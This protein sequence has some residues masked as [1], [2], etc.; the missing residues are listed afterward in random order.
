MKIQLKFF[1][2][3]LICFLFFYIIKFNYNLIVQN[4]EEIIFAE[5]QILKKVVDKNNN[6]KQLEIYSIIEPQKKK[7]QMDNSLNSNGKNIKNKKNEN[8]ENGFRIQI[9]SIKNKEKIQEVYRDYKLNFPEYFDTEFPNIEK[10]KFKNKGDF[11]RI[12]SFKKFNKA[13][14]QQICLKLKKKKFDCIIVR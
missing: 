10:I 7:L 12:K 5:T 6:S 11:Y 2:I 8:S 3:L 4:N 13:K 1:I 9:A 14:A